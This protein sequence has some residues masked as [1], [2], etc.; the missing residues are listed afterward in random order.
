[1][2]AST[3][4]ACGDSPTAP[5]PTQL[6]LSCPASFQTT[7]RDGRPV[8]VSYQAPLPLGGTAPVTVACTPP[9]GSTF[10]VKATTVSCK[11]TD[12][13]Q[14]TA[15]CS[16]TVTVVPP[17]YLQYTRFLAFGDSLTEG[18]DGLASPTG[19]GGYVPLVVRPEIAY[20]TRLQQAL[21]A[22]YVAQSP[23]VVNRGVGGEKAT[24]GVSRLPTEIVN[25]R[26]EVVLLL[27]GANDIFGGNTAG[28]TPAASALRMMVRDTRSRGLPVYLA[29]L[30]PEN[31]A[32]SR[33]GGAAL[34][35]PLNDLIRRVASEEGAAL[36]DLYAAF[37]GDL[38]LI[39]P[40]GLHPNEAG[41]LR[42]AET[43]FAVIRERLETP[44]PGVASA[45]AAAQPAG[46]AQ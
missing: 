20:P 15:S 29:T 10:P 36:V 38:T 8:T 25:V 42:M 17:P 9:S 30:P 39:G 19:I 14:A 35:V 2:F 24:T 22:R 44:F 31:P 21:V 32:G 18:Q 40:D 7:S 33:G 6:T 37:N 46:G 41:Y 34:V 5:T 45:T 23:Q 26:P 11:A 16:F 1:L 4:A 13:K 3:F 12:A 28:V 43:F 27:E